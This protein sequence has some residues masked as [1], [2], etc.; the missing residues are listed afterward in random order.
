[1]KQITSAYSHNTD[2]LNN[3]PAVDM[4]KL[5]LDELCGKIARL[6]CDEKLLTHKVEV[7]GIHNY[8]TLRGYVMNEDQF[9]AL[10]ILITELATKGELNI[11][12]NEALAVLK[13]MFDGAF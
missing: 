2:T 7:R 3:I 9:R 8:H 12:Q 4:D 13:K 11:E 1:M 6:L 5:I 10:R